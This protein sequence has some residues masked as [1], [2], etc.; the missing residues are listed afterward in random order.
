[1]NCIICICSQGTVL[2][3]KS[4]LGTMTFKVPKRNVT[5]QKTPKLTKINYGLCSSIA[6]NL[7]WQTSSIIIYNKHKEGSNF[8]IGVQINVDFQIYEREILI[9]VMTIMMYSIKIDRTSK[10]MPNCIQF[11]VKH[12]LLSSIKCHEN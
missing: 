7:E 6:I 3:C 8:L 1:L 4:I 9:V 11:E 10:V 12:K 5:L 2:G